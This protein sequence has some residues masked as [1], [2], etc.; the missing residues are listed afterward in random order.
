MKISIKMST[1]YTHFILTSGFEYIH[2]NEELMQR[3]YEMTGKEYEYEDE[4]MMTI[5]RE[6]KNHQYKIYHVKT[7][8]LP[9]ISL[10]RTFGCD[11]LKFLSEKYKIDTIK[12][13]LSS[14]SDN[15][16]AIMLIESVIFQELKSPILTDVEYLELIKNT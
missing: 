3:Y 12:K 6:N 2:D 7:N 15:T 14:E 16:G 9:Y 13:I 11:E 10:N 8:M 1:R 4:E 5:L